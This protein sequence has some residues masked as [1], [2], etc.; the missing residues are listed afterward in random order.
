[1]RDDEAISKI[2]LRLRLLRCARNDDT[3]FMLGLDIKTALS[4]LRPSPFGV[5]LVDLSLPLP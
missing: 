5:G 1:M 4:G 3:Q 2:A